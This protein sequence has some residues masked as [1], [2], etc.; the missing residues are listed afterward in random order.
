MFAWNIKP[1]ASL[2]ITKESNPQITPIF[3]CNLWMPLGTRPDYC[4]LI[5]PALK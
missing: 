3:L 2:V 4:A 1:A 5:I